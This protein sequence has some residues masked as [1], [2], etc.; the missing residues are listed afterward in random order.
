MQ[1]QGHIIRFYTLNKIQDYSVICFSKGRA[2]GCLACSL[3]N[4]EMLADI[5]RCVLNMNWVRK[6]GIIKCIPNYFIL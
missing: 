6:L 4:M 3:E 1:I 5:M 2:N